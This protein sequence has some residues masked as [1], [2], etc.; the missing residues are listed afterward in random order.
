MTS[1]SRRRVSALSTR[2]SSRSRVLAARSS[3][4][5]ITHR[6]T[7]GPSVAAPLFELV[8]SLSSKRATYD[9][10]SDTRPS[11]SLS[12]AVRYSNLELF[13]EPN[14]ARQGGAAPQGKLSLG[15]LSDGSQAAAVT[16]VSHARSGEMIRTWS[17]WLP[18]CICPD[19]SDGT[20]NGRECPRPIVHL[21]ATGVPK[22]NARPLLMVPN[23]SGRL[24][25]P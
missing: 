16:T 18:F 1:A 25:T 22:R 19:A 23:R 8:R 2:R 24:T 13:A 15:V 12:R 4:W 17:P 20:H 10:R 9:W 5:T 21:S 3:R 7:G 6:S 11:R 14:S